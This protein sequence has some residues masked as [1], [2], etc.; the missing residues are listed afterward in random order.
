MAAALLEAGSFLLLQIVGAHFPDG[1][2]V[3]VQDPVHLAGLGL[4]PTRLSQNTFA[5]VANWENTGGDGG[6]D[7]ENEADLLLLER[8][9]N[10]H[11][12]RGQEC[13]WLLD[14]IVNRR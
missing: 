14:Q 4:R 12:A 10:Q 7:D 2:E 5:D 8:E 1:G 13:G 3:L 6:Q 11:A 9:V